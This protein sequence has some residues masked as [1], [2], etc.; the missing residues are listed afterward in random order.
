MGKP[1]ALSRRPD[2]PRGHEDN[3]EVTLLDPSVF[4]IRQSEAVLVHGPEAD[5]LDR[6]RQSKD[7]DEPVV[8]ALRELDAG[9]I[10][11]DE[12]EREGDIILHRGR[13]YVPRDLQ[14]RADIL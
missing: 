8:K 10:R 1:D 2:H 3:S 4:E 5:L 13:V 14:L 9:T 11:A 7:L 6:I 12:W